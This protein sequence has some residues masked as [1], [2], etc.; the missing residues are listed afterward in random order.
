MKNPCLFL[1]HNFIFCDIIC[2]WLDSGEDD[3]KIERELTIGKVP[4]G[5]EIIV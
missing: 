5:E 3:G 4:S 1:K 2:R